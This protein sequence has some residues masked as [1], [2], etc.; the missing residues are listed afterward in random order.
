MTALSCTVPSISLHEAPFSLPW[1]SSV[2]AKVIATNLYGDSAYSVAGN[3]GVIYAVPD[4]PVNLSENL[5]ERS[6]STLGLTWED[7][8][9]AGGTPVID[10]KVVVTG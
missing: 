4:V 6:G 9:D 8:S 7:G 1:S 10:Y 5:E 2:Y 3:G